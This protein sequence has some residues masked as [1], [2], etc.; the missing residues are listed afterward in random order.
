M[1]DI[2]FLKINEIILRSGATSLFDVQRWTF[3]VG[4]S[5]FKPTPHGINATCEYLQNNFM[6]M[7]PSTVTKTKKAVPASRAQPF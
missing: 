5:A 3:D 7:S 6:L 4:R 1:F 2:E